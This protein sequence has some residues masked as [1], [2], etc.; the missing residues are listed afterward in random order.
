MLLTIPE[1]TKMSVGMALILHMTR[2]VTTVMTAV[3]LLHLIVHAVLC[4]DITPLGRSHHALQI[5]VLE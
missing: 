2:E 1:F 4:R 5:Q 3:L